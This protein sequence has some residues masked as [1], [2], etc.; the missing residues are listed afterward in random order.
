M[1]DSIL[2]VA[3]PPVLRIMAKPHNAYIEPSIERRQRPALAWI[4][5]LHLLPIIISKTCGFMHP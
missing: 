2:V 4:A 5:L 3:V 1:E